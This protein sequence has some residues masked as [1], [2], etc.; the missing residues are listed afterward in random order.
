MRPPAV[1]DNS[2]HGGPRVR[3]LRQV[4]QPDQAAR[5][6]RVGVTCNILSRVTYCHVSRLLMVFQGCPRVP[7]IR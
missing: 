6:L 1:R 4:Q 5:R 2:G 3:Q 7:S